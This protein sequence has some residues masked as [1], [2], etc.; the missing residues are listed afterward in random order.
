MEPARAEA[1]ATLASLEGLPGPTAALARPV[2]GLLLIDAYT[3]SSA[4]SLTPTRALPA[5]ATK[6]TKANFTTYK[7]LMIVYKKDVASVLKRRSTA[8]FR[9]KGTAE[10][11][12]DLDVLVRQAHVP[13]ENLS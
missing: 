5:L 4:W 9:G 12:R 1:L 8:V 3:P 10:A 7:R 13:L 11:D 2:G 6:Q